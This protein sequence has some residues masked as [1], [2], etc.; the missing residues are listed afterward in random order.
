M[1]DIDGTLI[2]ALQA[3]KAMKRFETAI[4]HVF[5]VDVT[6]DFSQFSSTFN[7]MGD[8]GI[9]I[10]LLK[11]HTISSSEVGEKIHLV[12]DEFISYLNELRKELI[13]YKKIDDAHMLFEKVHSASHLVLG[14][15]TGNLGKSARWKL[16]SVG[17]PSNYFQVAVY[18]HEAENRNDLAKLVVPKIIEKFQESP[19]PTDIIFIG[20]TK[21]DILC[22]RSIGARVIIVTTGWKTNTEELAS[23]KP[24]LLVDSLLDPK[25]LNLLSLT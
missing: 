19:D 7:G 25:V 15:L 16:D 1:F 11:G 12:E 3:Q 18:G 13:L 24:D 21:H 8:R 14:T 23:L 9:L 2:T 6:F 22:A 10:E 20:D 5:H 4:Q 17:I